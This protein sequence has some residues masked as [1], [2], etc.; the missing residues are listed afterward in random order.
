MNLA[1]FQVPV[2][3]RDGVPKAD[4]SKVRAYGP[5]LE[6]GNVLPGKPARFTVDSSDTGPADVDVDILDAATGKPVSGSGGPLSGSGLGSGLSRR[7]S[8]VQKPDGNHEVTYVPPLVGE[9]YDVSEI[10]GFKF[11]RSE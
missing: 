11:N 3:T 9:P 8:V 10:N 4:A 2:S 7:P 6:P 5:G 1:S